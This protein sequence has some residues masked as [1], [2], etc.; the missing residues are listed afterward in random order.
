MKKDDLSLPK[1]R[2]VT[3]FEDLKATAKAKGHFDG[4]VLLNGGLRSSKDISY[5]EDEDVWEIW[6]M[7]DGS[8]D[9]FTDQELQD[10]FIGEA[11]QKGALY[12]YV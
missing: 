5:I 12:E 8:V 11:I 4:F 9:Q 2:R 7:I 3:D 6:N 1:R 10:G